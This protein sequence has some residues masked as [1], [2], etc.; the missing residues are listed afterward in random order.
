MPNNT[1]K[2]SPTESNFTSLSAS[3]VPKEGIDINDFDFDLYLEKR[4]LGAGSKDLIY[5][6]KGE[7][8]G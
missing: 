2:E 3:I 1:G 5:D 6:G 7:Y 4:D 8:Q